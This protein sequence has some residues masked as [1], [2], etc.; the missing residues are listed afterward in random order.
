MRSVNASRKLLFAFI[1]LFSIALVLFWCDMA[2]ASLNLIVENNTGATIEVTNYFTYLDYNNYRSKRVAP[3]TSIVLNNFLSQGRNEVRITLP[4]I[5]IDKEVVKPIWVSGNAQKNNK[6]EIY[7]KDFG[8]YNMSDRLNCSESLAKHNKADTRADK[9]VGVWKD[10]IHTHT[11]CTNPIKGLCKEY[12]VT[13]TFS[14][15]STGN[16]IA[17]WGNFSLRGRLNGT[18][19]SFKIYNGSQ[20]HGEGNFEFSSDFRDSRTSEV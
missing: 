15:D 9:I 3:D 1:H 18:I 16:L 12:E 11:E 5:S 2:H 14:K 10:T 20:L 19:Y 17:T 4:C 8:S 6:I 7:E 13:L